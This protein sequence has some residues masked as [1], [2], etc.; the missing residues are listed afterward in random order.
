VDIKYSRLLLVMALGGVMFFNGC[1]VNLPKDYLNDG[2]PEVVCP[3]GITLLDHE[4][5]LPLGR[6]KYLGVMNNPSDCHV[7]WI[8]DDPLIL[9]LSSIGGSVRATALGQATVHAY[10]GY[11]FDGL[12]VPNDQC[13]ITVVPNTVA[14]MIFTTPDMVLQEGHT[15][16]A[17]MGVTMRDLEGFIF[18]PVTSPVWTSSDTTIAAITSPHIDSNNIS[19]A[20]A[21]GLA[22]GRAV[23]T[24]TYSGVGAEEQAVSDSCVVM[25]V[26]PQG[27]R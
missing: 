8:V 25:V 9:A 12:D 19:R 21:W 1:E 11:L 5:T 10:R 4:L 2:E 7:S 15:S 16:P 20:S 6:S 22:A 13:L 24:A 3:E 26:A 23:I 18:T 27:T 14:S 17:S